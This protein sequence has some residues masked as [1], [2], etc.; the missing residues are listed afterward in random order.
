M[1]FICI[2]I[3]MSLH[4]PAAACIPVASASTVHYRPAIHCIIKRCNQALTNLLPSPTRAE[5]TVLCTNVILPVM[6]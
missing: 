5:G 4:V 1:Q 3:F 6:C 2:A